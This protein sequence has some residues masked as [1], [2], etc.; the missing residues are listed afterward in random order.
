MFD[1]PEPGQSGPT[2]DAATTSSINCGL[3]ERRDR[4][5][6][7]SGIDA[8]L[9]GRQAG[10]TGRIAAPQRHTSSTTSRAEPVARTPNSRD[11]AATLSAEM[12]HSG[13]S[14]PS[15]DRGIF[16]FPKCGTETGS[17]LA[18]VE[19]ETHQPAERA[20]ACN[21]GAMRKTIHSWLTPSRTVRKAAGLSA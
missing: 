5:G 4:F 20:D 3:S 10:W 9:L 7:V 2:R 1:S 14:I 17:T 21:A 15:R 12:R 6:C 16:N 11:Q 19:I 18:N 13:P 8:I